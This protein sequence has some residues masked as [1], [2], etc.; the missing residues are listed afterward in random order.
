VIDGLGKTV[1]WLLAIVGGV[2]VVRHYVPKLMGG[3][4]DRPPAL[5]TGEHRE[6]RLLSERPTIVLVPCAVGGSPVPG[7]G[8]P[9][10]GMQ[11]SPHYRWCYLVRG[12]DTAG[13]I[14]ERI[15]G[16][17][18]RYIE[19]LTANPHIPKRGTMGVVVGPD[20]WDFAE[21]TLPEGTKI[22]LS[23]TL[24][25]WV[26]QLGTAA[27]TYVPWPPDPRM[28]V[29]VP[30]EE[31]PAAT[32]AATST[33]GSSAPTGWSDGFDYMGDAAS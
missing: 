10:A 5:P 11:S 26:D 23:Q 16:D 21:G 31:V 1:L 4:G 15:A 18:A 27:G 32:H 29:E 6:R 9:K 7:G 33:S 24:N 3:G 30:A 22:Y 2:I 13:L 28:I 19:L 8:S 12:G 17:S 20:A 25:S 14:A